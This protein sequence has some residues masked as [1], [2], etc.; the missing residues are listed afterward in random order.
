M[1]LKEDGFKVRRISENL[2]EV[3]GIEIG[4][5]FDSNRKENVHFSTMDEA[6]EFVFFVENLMK[7]NKPK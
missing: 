2:I 5:L 7:E 6:E 4:M 3:S 1:K